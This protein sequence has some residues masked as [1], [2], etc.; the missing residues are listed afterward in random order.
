VAALTA[1]LLGSCDGSDPL[2]LIL[3]VGDPSISRLPYVI[4][5]DQ[6]IFQKYGLDVELRLREPGNQ[7]K[8][9]NHTDAVTTFLRAIGVTE[10]PPPDIMTNGLGPVVVQTTETMRANPYQ[11]AIASTDC[12]VRAHIIARRG[13]NSLEEL[14]GKRIGVSS[15]GATSG[16]HALLLA[17]RMGWDPVIDISIMA[18]NDDDITLLQNG[19]LDAIVGYETAYADALAE[20]LPI[21]A[22]TRD[23]GEILAGN[24][25]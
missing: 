8:I 4:A 23:W 24:S 18:G 14:K 11:V 7:G 12:V 16:T 3:T 20:G 19:Q 5:Y 10:V 15:L 9:I 6:G 25:A 13:I 21:L 17:K 22:D 1:I 2:P